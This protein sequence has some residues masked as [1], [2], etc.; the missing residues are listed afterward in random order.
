MEPVYQDIAE[1]FCGVYFQY[2]TLARQR[3]MSGLIGKAS[4]AELFSAMP[5]GVRLDRPLR[6]PAAMSEIE[7]TQA[8]EALSALNRAPDSLACFLGAGAYD[9]FVPGVVDSLASQGEFVTAYTPYWAEASQ[10]NLQVFYE[11]Q[12]LRASFTFLELLWN[13]KMAKPKGFLA[14]LC[15]L[16]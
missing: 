4:L 7:L 12:T 15:T 13:G 9:H 8:A 3:Y 16:L 5:E 2:I 10:R 11:F 1:G 6:L 14:T